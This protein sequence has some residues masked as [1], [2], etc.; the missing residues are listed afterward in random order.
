[1]KSSYQFITFSF[2][3]CVWIQLR[4]RNIENWRRSGICLGLTLVYVNNYMP[5]LG[6]MELKRKLVEDDGL[7]DEDTDSEDEHLADQIESILL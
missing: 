7:L 5:G 3:F 1:M 6:E 4:G 2:F